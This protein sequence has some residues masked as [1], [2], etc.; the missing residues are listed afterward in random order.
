MLKEG[1]KEGRKGNENRAKWGK[2][3]KKYERSKK[4]ERE[5]RAKHKII[6]LYK[7]FSLIFACTKV[8]EICVSFYTGF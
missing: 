1:K 6:V 5:K 3:G 8:Y 4:W 2:N 7:D